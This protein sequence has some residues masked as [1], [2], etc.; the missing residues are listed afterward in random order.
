MHFVA[1]RA[2]LASKEELFERP[3]VF[4]DLRSVTGSTQGLLFLPAQPR[5]MGDLGRLLIVRVGRSW[6]MTGLTGMQTFRVRDALVCCSLDGLSLVLVAVGADRWVVEELPSPFPFCRL[7]LPFLHR[8]DRG[9]SLHG[10][11]RSPS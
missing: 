2:L 4:G 6:A 8:R 7:L 1:S 9:G 3:S 11:R 10:S 5:W